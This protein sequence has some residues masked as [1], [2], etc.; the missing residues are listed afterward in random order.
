M[1]SRTKA[2]LYLSS[3]FVIS[4]LMFYLGFKI[5]GNLIGILGILASPQVLNYFIE[6]D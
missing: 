4:V 1:T 3:M 2:A 5:T 6:R